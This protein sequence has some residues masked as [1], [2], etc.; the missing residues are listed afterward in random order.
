M[1]RFVILLAMCL[2]LLS[3][4]QI[5]WTSTDSLAPGIEYCT[6]SGILDTSAQQIHL[7][8]VDPEAYRLDLL[9]SD[10]TRYRTSDFVQNTDALLAINGG[11]FDMRDGGSVSYCEVDGLTMATTRNARARVDPTLSNLNAVIYTDTTQTVHLL[12]ALRDRLYE[13]SSA[14]SDLLVTG[15]L[16]LYKDTLQKLGDNS[17]SSKRHPRTAIGF[18]G[19]SLHLLTV[20]GRQEKAAGMSLSELQQFM[21]DLGCHTAVNLDG[22]GSTTAWVKGRGVVNQPSDFFGER[23]VANIW[24]VRSK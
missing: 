20:D 4:A 19:T 22:G 18:D 15:P 2:P 13:L 10:T 16:L 5:T 9:Y 21:D 7:F 3:P 14:E 17:F 12:P 1:L 24:I 8:R 23:E 11:F 6:F